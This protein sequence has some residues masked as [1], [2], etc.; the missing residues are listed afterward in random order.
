MGSSFFTLPPP[1]P[2]FIPYLLTRG[3][4][5]MDR[6]E[7]KILESNF[8]F[9][10][11]LNMSI[12]KR[13]PIPLNYHQSPTS[14]LRALTFIDPLKSSQN[15]KCYAVAII[16]CSWQNHGSARQEANH[17]QLL[18]SS[19]VSTHLGLKQKYFLFI[20]LFFKETKISDSHYTRALHMLGNL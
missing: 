2:G 8:C 11:P 1:V 15:P 16:T 18:R 9:V 13:Q 6:R 3:Q 4:R 12:Y 17:G 14:L 19:P 10:F 5:R 7:I 20:F